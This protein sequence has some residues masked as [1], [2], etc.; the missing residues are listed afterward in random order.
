VKTRRDGDTIVITLGSGEAVVLRHALMSVASAYRTSPD[1]IDPRTG[2]VW[3]STRGCRAADMSAEDAAEWI[4]QMHAF[5][6]ENL[7]LIDGWL[8]QLAK[9]TSRRTV[10]AL[11]LGH[12]DAFVRVLNDHRLRAAAENDIGQDEMDLRDLGAAEEL[13]PQRQTA[14]IEI[15]FLAW[16]IEEILRLTA[17]DATRWGDLA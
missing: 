2:A 5:K 10:L 14:L 11:M 15:H 7:S 8:R 16:I 6:S 4:G 3:Y 12:A 13:E 9:R 1:K 17:P